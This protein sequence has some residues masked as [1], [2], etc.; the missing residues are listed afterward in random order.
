M[1]KKAEKSSLLF[2]G[3]HLSAII[4]IGKYCVTQFSNLTIYCQCSVRGLWSA[5]DPRFRPL[6]WVHCPK[7]TVLDL[8]SWVHCPGSTVLSPLSWVHYPGS[9][10]LSPLSWVHCPES[11]IFSPQSWTVPGP[12]SLAPIPRS[13]FKCPLSRCLQIKTTFS[14]LCILYMG[15]ALGILCIKT[16]MSFASAYWMLLQKLGLNNLV[17]DYPTIF[18]QSL[19]KLTKTKTKNRSNHFPWAW[20]NT[21]VWHC[22]W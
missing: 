12:W 1:K 6:S 17:Q 9:T 5:V 8:L 7:S 16:W 18:Y 21:Q 20:A 4:L 10:V 15:S 2:H 3:N 11:S 22:K 14:Q 13:W 19:H